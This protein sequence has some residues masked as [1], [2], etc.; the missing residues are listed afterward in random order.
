MS[1]TWAE[2]KRGNNPPQFEAVPAEHPATRK[3]TVASPLPLGRQDAGAAW[4][5]RAVIDPI[6]KRGFATTTMTLKSIHGIL[7]N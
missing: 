6:K 3:A 2:G 5:S 1:L 7:G 4:L